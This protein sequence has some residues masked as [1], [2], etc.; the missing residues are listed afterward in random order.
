MLDWSVLSDTQSASPGPITVTAPDRATLMADLEARLAAGQ[1]FS[2]ATLNLDHVVK[3]RA[4]P[5]F[6]SAY[7][8]H[9]HV[10]ADGN[11]I[12]WLCKLS[13]QPVALIPGSELVAPVAG[14]AARNGVGVALLG[15]TAP[16]LAA[17]ADAL[18]AHA[19][20][21][22][23]VAQIAPPM[24]FDPDG[25]SAETAIAEL[26]ASGAGLCFLALGAPKQ[27]LFAARA[28]Q[29]L[30]HMGFLSIGAGLDFL[31]GQQKRAPRLVQR[32]ALEWLWRLM[33]SPKRLAA[34]Y[35]S[36]FAV[37][38]RATQAALRA[39]NARPSQDI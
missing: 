18:R 35:A 7:A 28:Q 13:G 17:A 5:A 39:R 19:P 9:S 1:G 34:R 20:G 15:S 33:G 16:S 29:A 2:V 30:P 32:L 27:E 8:A 31:A 6:R 37:L 25:A 38:P 22:R 3:I 21:L 14:L 11:P 12:V 24:G 36:C 4:N 26:K 10:T 23:V